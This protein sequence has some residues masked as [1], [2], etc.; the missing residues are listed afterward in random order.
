MGRSSID[1]PAKP[2]SALTISRPA[3]NASWSTA[4]VAMTSRPKA[5]ATNQGADTADTERT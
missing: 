3:M 4:K 2:P 5:A 1:A